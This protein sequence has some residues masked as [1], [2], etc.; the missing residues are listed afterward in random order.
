M[1]LF[2]LGFL[3]ACFFSPD[4]CPGV[5]L[6]CHKV[7]LSFWRN[8]YTNFHSDCTTLHSRQCT[9]VPFSPQP[10]PHLLFVSLMT[11]ILTGVRW[12]LTVLLI[13]ISLMISDV[14]QLF[15]CLLNIC[16]SFLEKCLFSHFAYSFFF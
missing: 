13:C 2:K 15:M 10:H 9:R 14:E 1:Y 4:L 5:E 16:I 7:V 11:A 6:L 12:C 8:L 3:F